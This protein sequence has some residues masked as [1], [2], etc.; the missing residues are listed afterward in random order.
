MKDDGSGLVENFVASKSS[1]EFACM[2]KRDG[3]YGGHIIKLGPGNEEATFAALR[4]FKGGMQV[5][6][7]YCFTLLIML[8]TICSTHVKH[9]M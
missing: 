4:E 5:G 1:G 8:S 2:Y 6:G 7:E 3:L 9:Y